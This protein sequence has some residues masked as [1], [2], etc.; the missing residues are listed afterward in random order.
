MKLLVLK[1]GKTHFGPIGLIFRVVT[2]FLFLLFKR[3]ITLFM[4]KL[5]PF[6]FNVTF[7]LYRTKNFITFWLNWPIR[8]DWTIKPDWPN[9]YFLNIELFEKKIV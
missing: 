2:F 9:S 8:P 4:K 3:G 1:G 6:Q 7:F 5:V